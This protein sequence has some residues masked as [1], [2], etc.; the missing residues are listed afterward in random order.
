MKGIIAE[1][2]AVFAIFACMLLP[3]SVSADCRRV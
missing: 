2:I 1:K 3:D